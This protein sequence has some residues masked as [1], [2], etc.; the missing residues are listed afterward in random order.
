MT[1]TCVWIGPRCSDGIGNECCTEPQKIGNLCSLH[2]WMMMANSAEKRYAEEAEY[3]NW[4]AVGQKRMENDLRQQIA[5]LQSSLASE[6]VHRV[7]A[8]RQGMLDSAEIA[9]AD[10]APDDHID[11]EHGIPTHGQ[12]IAKAIREKAGVECVCH[13]TSSRNCPVHGNGGE[14]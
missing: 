6:K 1:P 9:E 14:R 2:Y 12:R 10:I 11:R 8:Y 4:Y 3:H 7:E 13:E 5:T